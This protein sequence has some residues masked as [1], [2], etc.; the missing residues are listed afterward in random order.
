MSQN[1]GILYIVAT[2]IG[3]LGDFSFRAVEVLKTV[4]L[5]AAE[6]TRHSRHLLDHYGIDNILHSLHEYNER[7]KSEVMLDRLLKGESIAIIS[8]AGTPLISDP[9]FTLVRLAQQA[10]I[11]IVPIPGACA[12]IAALSASGLPTNHF[13]FK[14]FPPRNR[15]ARKTLFQKL[16]DTQSTIIFYESSH[17][18]SDCLVDLQAVFPP[19]REIAIARELTKVHETIVRS[20]LADIH[21]LFETDPFMSKG[22]FVILIE[23]ASSPDKSHQISQEQERILR[24]LLNECSLKQAVLLTSEITGLRKKV[25][26]QRALE[27]EHRGEDG[28]E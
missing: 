20:T 4:D 2:P 25:L 8:D 13:I 10:G 22:E 18:I 14:G 6:D 27:V 19:K 16:R 15:S 11:D 23:G 26:Y 5:I 24:I 1:N 21:K 9:G 12:L 17:R 28:N 7:T 3:N